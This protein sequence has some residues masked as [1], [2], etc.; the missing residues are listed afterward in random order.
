MCCYTGLDTRRACTRVVLNQAQVL[1][2]R[3]NRR[4]RCACGRHG[5]VHDVLPDVAVPEDHRD[6]AAAARAGQHARP[7][8]GELPGPDSGAAVSG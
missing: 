8:V 5:A 6:D 7:R 2:A 1:L 4:L 3:A